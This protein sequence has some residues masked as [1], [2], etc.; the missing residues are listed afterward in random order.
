[1]FT[2]FSLN[3]RGRLMQFERPA[4]M[5][6]LNITPDSF[7]ASSRATA[8]LDIARR[9]E[10]MIQ[11]GADILDVGACST[12]PGADVVTADEELARLRHGLEI[13]RRVSPDIPVSVDTFRSRV[14]A[15]AVEECGADIIN[16]ISGGEADGEMFDT[17]SLLHVPYIMMHMR[18]T[19]ETMQRLTDYT[20]V[21]AEVAEWLQRRV[22]ELSLRGVSDVIVDP[23]LGFA[24]TVGQNYSLLGCTD[25][26]GG[27]T[28]KPVLIGLS[29]KSMITKPLGITAD[30][31]L[32][33]TTAL[34][35]YALRQGASII[36]VHDVKEG[37]M[38]VELNELLNGN[39]IFND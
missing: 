16:D 27:I 23:G 6:I 25:I 26:I 1:M 14:A 35:L 4:V 24:K 29:R 37:R 34:N 10:S 39:S 21:A 28:G 7:Y 2:P 32:A 9:V 5:G 15:I 11:D 30:E 18:G 33:P 12:R 13:L 17:V 19:P 8:D 36:R 20:D 22:R 38:A 3:L 31:A